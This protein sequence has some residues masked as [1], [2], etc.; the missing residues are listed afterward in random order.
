M[1]LYTN[2]KSLS[3]YEIE[4]DTFRNPAGL[5]SLGQNLWQ[6]SANSGDPLARSAGQGGAGSVTSGALEGSNVDIASEFTR[7][8]TA[9]RGFQVNSRV[10]QTTDSILQELSGLIRG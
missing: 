7:L 8:I 5:S 3:L 2:G 4:I 10:I 6:V 9:Q 1:G